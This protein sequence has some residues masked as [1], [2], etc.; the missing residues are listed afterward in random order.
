[1]TR[2]LDIAVIGGDGIGAVAGLNIPF[3]GAM[4]RFRRV[5][6]LVF[7]PDTLDIL[8]RRI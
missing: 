8:V 7:G 5:Q 4:P 3:L 1:M 6:S 2:V